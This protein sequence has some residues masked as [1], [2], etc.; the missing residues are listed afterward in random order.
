MVV[1]SCGEQ[2]ACLAERSI[3]CP[4][5]SVPVRNQVSMPSARLRRAIASKTIVSRHPR[6]HLAETGE[7]FFASGS[8]GERRLVDTPSA[9][10]TASNQRNPY[11]TG[12]PPSR[13]MRRCRHSRIRGGL[14]HEKILYTPIRS[15]QASRNAKFTFHVT[16]SVCPE[17]RR[18]FDVIGTIRN[19]SDRSG[20][21]R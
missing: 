9:S 12:S 7:R 11:L 21:R 16:D 2:P 3:F 6:N 13:Q 18:A 10:S 19:F 5:S 17:K 1:N 4:C 20:R 8:K 15:G 14:S